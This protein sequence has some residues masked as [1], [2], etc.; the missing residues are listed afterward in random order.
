MPGA[1]W[2]AAVGATARVPLLTK[3]LPP[4]IVPPTRSVPPPDLESPLVA[5]ILELTVAVTPGSV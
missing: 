1:V 2:I 3:R 4:V 5:T